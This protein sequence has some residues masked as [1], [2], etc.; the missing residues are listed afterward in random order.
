MR[1]PLKALLITGSLVAA[2]LGPAVPAAAAELAPT[3]NTTNFACA[4]NGVCEVG[5]GNV[6]MPFAAGLNVFGDGVPQAPTEK[7]YGYFFRMTII[8][9]SLPPGLQLS[10]PS[11]E[12]T[13]AGTPAQA[14]TYPFTVQFTAS[15][16][17]PNGIPAVAGLSGT[18]QLSITIGTGGSDRPA[19][20]R[21]R[22][23]GHLFRLNVSGYDANVSLLWSASVTSTA[24]V[25]FSNQPNAVTSNNGGFGVNDHI[26]DPCGYASCSLTV[27]NS[28]G[29]SGTVIM[30]P[31]TY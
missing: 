17:G 24:K 15:Q 7:Y 12:W 23:N 30:P 20:V 25:I 22:Y 21:A 18:Q 1:S 4:S 16:T 13:V 10:A 6:G 5:P 26:S 14:G 28:L 2:G 3:L 29:F 19:G 31:P 11:T 27:T 9:G 8:S